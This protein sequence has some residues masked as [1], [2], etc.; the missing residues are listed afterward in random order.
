[1]SLVNEERTAIKNQTFTI[2]NLSP[3]EIPILKTSE[4][5]ISN[6]ANFDLWKA[7]NTFEQKQNGFYGV[8]IRIHLGNISSA[9]SRTLIQSLRGF[10]PEQI[11]WQILLHVL[12]LILVI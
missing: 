5:E 2:P 7:T 8:Y 11:V 3:V 9:D 10:V 1:M 6:N 12:E 4:L